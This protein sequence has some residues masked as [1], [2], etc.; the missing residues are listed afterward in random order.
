MKK[1]TSEDLRVP[2]N[3]RILYTILRD[4]NYSEDWI[5]WATI[6]DVKEAVNDLL[7]KPGTKLR[8]WYGIR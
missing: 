1:F 8:N 6:T 7:D 3:I 5:T 4:N 2:R